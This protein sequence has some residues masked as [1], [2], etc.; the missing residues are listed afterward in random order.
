MS[1]LK[2]CTVTT[3]VLCGIEA[4]ECKLTV[5]LNKDG[6]Y[7]FRVDGMP[8]G[9]L[10]ELSVRVSCALRERF[11]LNLYGSSVRVTCSASPVSG[12]YEALDL[13]IAVAIAR[14]SGLLQAETEPLLL[15]GE[16]SLSGDLRPTRGVASYATLAKSLGRALVAP[17]RN[18]LEAMRVGGAKVYSTPTL[19]AAFDVVRGVRG[20]CRQEFYTA[21]AGAPL[22]VVP[23]FS[24]VRGQPQAVRAALVAAVGG[25]NLL[26]VGPPGGGKTM[27]ARRI[28]GILPPFGLEEALE[29]GKVHSVAGLEID[30]LRFPPGRPFRAPHHTC[31]GPGLIGGGSTVRPGEVSLAHGGVLL[32]DEL[33]EFSRGA[34]EALDVPLRTG[35]VSFRRGASTVV[36]PAR[37]LLVG[38]MNPCPCGFLGGYR[39]C[40]C[41]ADSVGRYKARIKGLLPFFDVAC[42][43]PSLHARELVQPPGPT[44]AELAGRV[45]LARARLNYTALGRVAGR[46][47]VARVARVL[48]ALDGEPKA[49]A[50]HREEATAMTALLRTMEEG[51]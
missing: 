33:P 5:G 28:P 7:G 12:G 26:L 39:E 30:W 24:E 27:L 37:F 9:A 3:A 29:A 14:C 47:R 19:D 49:R 41:S 35:G 23:D 17:S 22:G 11:Q 2:S 45:L 10:R 51:S 50:K 6:P 13:P 42:E 16:L 44:T 36:Y 40:S 46:D 48:A 25:F 15:V 4:V 38:A 20:L 1:E 18:I 21:P 43:V 32:L 8:P 34:L 31:S